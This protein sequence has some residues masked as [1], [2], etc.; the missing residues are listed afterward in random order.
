VAC[1]VGESAVGL[2]DRDVVVVEPLERCEEARVDP[3]PGRDQEPPPPS[4]D[5]RR[6]PPRPLIHDPACLT[7]APTSSRVCADFGPN[8]AS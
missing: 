2:G 6:I 8:L 7:S 3:R 5:H 1:D 4:V